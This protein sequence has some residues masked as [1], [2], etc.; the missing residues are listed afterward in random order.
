MVMFP[1]GS[2]AVPSL[3]LE[4]LLF[5]PYSTTPDN[6]FLECRNGLPSLSL[7]V[8]QP[9]TF[10]PTLIIRQRH[11]RPLGNHP[12]LRRAIE[13]SV[14]RIRTTGG[15]IPKVESKTQVVL[16]RHAYKPTDVLMDL[17]DSHLQLLASIKY[18]GITFT[19]MLRCSDF[20]TTLQTTIPGR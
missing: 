5:Y 6:L 14:I 3:A 18:L 1:Y 16:F 20:T 12:Q 4:G 9:Q 2:P 19:P 13:N 7:P 15:L 8:G 17:W 11:Y 10:N